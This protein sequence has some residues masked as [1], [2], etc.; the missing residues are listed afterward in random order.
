LIEVGVA[1][2]PTKM[3]KFS[4]KEYLIKIAWSI[5]NMKYIN[6]VRLFCAK[7]I[8]HQFTRAEK[9]K[10]QNIREYRISDAFLQY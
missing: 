10:Q 3:E 1:H 7:L 8:C 2:F 5:N 6:W 4:S 9:K